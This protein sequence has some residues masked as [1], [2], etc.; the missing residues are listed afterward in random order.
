MQQNDSAPSGAMNV[1]IANVA[2]TTSLTIIITNAT[3]NQ[4][5]NVATTHASMNV[6]WPSATIA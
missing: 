4:P 1:A 5:G 3:L 6:T 2:L